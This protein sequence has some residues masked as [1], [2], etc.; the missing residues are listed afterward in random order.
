[1]IIKRLLFIIL[2]SFFLFLSLLEVFLRLNPKFINLRII[3]FFPD[4]NVKKKLLLDLHSSYNIK[5]FKKK[6]GNYYF[7][8]YKDT[9]YHPSPKEDL[10][11]GAKNF[12]FYKNGF[13]NEEND[14]KNL[15]II[16]VGDS[17]TYCTQLMPNDSW[18]KNIFDNIEKKNSINMGIPGTGPFQYN[19]LLRGS[20]N[21]NTK[22]I[23]YAYYEGNDLRDMLNYNSNKKINN[24]TN[25]E[26]K[27]KYY[28]KKILGELYSLNYTLALYRANYLYNKNINFKY[29]RISSNQ[30]FNVG[31]SDLDEIEYAKLINPNFN[32]NSKKNLA[33]FSHLLSKSF[34]E[35]NKIA[36]INNSIIIFIYIPSAYTAFG[37]DL[38]FYDEDIKRLVKNYSLISQKKFSATCDDQKLYCINTVPSFINYNQKYKIPSHFPWNVHLTKNGHKVISEEIKNYICN[39]FKNDK[40]F[41]KDCN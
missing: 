22:L 1:M 21:K 4:T 2:L 16:S 29:V 25:N 14:I 19:E 11:L 10:L 7:S 3:K 27:I 40:F 33:I 30:I 41:E 12:M 17:F 18:I 9:Y 39:N 6:I 8:L 20:V 38:S 35:A 37:D 36:K 28:V 15:H 34:S 23:I 32:N 5:T 31:N 24:L 13:C 26:N